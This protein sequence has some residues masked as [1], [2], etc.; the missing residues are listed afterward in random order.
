MRSRCPLGE[1][2]IEEIGVPKLRI[3]TGS[4]LKM[5]S[6][7]NFIAVVALVPIISYLEICAELRRIPVANTSSQSRI[8]ER[9]LILDRMV[10]EASNY[11]LES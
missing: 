6:C 3:L 10:S 2:S 1:S 8:D 5:H 9:W 7:K 11:G 4:L